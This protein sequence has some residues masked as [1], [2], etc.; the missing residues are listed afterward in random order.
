VL[1]AAGVDAIVASGFEAGGHRPS[2]LAAAEVSLHGTLA[3]VP[4]IV[5]AVGPYR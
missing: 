2:F 1:D 5:D 3:L 4:R